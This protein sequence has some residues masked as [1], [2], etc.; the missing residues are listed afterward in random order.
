MAETEPS[1]DEP[2][3]PGH[4]LFVPV[5]STANGMVSVRLGRLGGDTQRAGIAFTSLELLRQATNPEH[6]WIRLT[7][8]ALRALLRPMGVDRI[9]VDPMLVA[10]SLPDAP[11]RYGD[12]AGSNERHGRRPGDVRL[13]LPVQA[14]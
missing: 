5:R 6:P 2:P 10:P 8:S 11:P 7:T 13:R 1:S 12:G 14:G 4:L 3:Q 9:Q